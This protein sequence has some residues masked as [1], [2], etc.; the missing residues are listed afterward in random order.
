MIRVGTK[1]GRRS[2]VSASCPWWLAVWVGM[3]VAAVDLYIL[4]IVWSYKIT[5]WSVRLIA[6]G[7]GHVVGAVRAWSAA[8][9]TDGHAR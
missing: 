3:L 9:N 7:V 8:H 2:W 6:Q 4:A 5:M 1:L